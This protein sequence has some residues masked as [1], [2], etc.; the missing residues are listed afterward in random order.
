MFTARPLSGL[1]PYGPPALSFPEP[2]A[3]REGYVVEFTNESGQSWVGN[4]AITDKRFLKGVFSELGAEAV[5]VVAGGSGYIVNVNRQELVLDLGFFKDFWF[6]SELAG[7]VTAS[8][9]HFRAFGAGELLWESHR[10]SF[11]GLR[12]LE[13]SGLSLTGEAWDAPEDRWLPFTLNLE[14]GSVEGGSMT[15]R[16]FQT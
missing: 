8:Y 3:F 12:K 14:D 2:A 1:P 16:Q 5:F 15:A 4:F 7:L 13:R 9:T 6:V 10:I 11:D